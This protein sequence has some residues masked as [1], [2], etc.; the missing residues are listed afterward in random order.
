LRDVKTAGKPLAL[1]KKFD[2]KIVIM[3]NKHER[4]IEY[5]GATIKTPSQPL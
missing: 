2:V 1:A 4:S 5:P 3:L